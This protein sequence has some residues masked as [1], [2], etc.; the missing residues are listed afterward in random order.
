MTELLNPFVPPVE[1]TPGASREADALSI[2]NIGNLRQQQQDE[3]YRTA[4]GPFP[5]NSTESLTKQ[6]EF[7]GT[8]VATI[9]EE[10]LR[11]NG[12][13]DD[14]PQRA[15][16]LSLINRFSI[17]GP[18]HISADPAETAP[19]EFNTELDSEGNRLPSGRELFQREWDGLFGEPQPD[20]T[21]QPTV[22]HEAILTAATEKLGG[23]KTA[24]NLAF[25]DRMKT[26]FWKRRKAQRV[27]DARRTELDAVTREVEAAQI[28]KWQ[29]EGK[30]D[31]EVA[32]ALAERANGRV[33][34]R[35]KDRQE[36]MV[37]GTFLGKRYE[38]YAN[39]SRGKK[40]VAK[41]AIGLA[42]ASAVAAT[43]ATLGVGGAV[44]ATVGVA[45]SR[46]YRTYMLQQTELFASQNGPAP[47]PIEFKNSD[48]SLRTHDEIIGEA[49][50]KDNEQLD[51]RIDDG[52]KV[53]RKAV[54]M[55]MG[56]VALGGAVHAV[57]HVA[58]LGIWNDGHSVNAKPQ[59]IAS[60]NSPETTT[61]NSGSVDTGTTPDKV[62]EKIPTMGGSGSESA[63]TGS[64][65]EIGD[66]AHVIKMGEGWYQTF[67]EM[68]IANPHDQAALLNDDVLMG[69]L[70][71]IKLAYPD[72]NIGGWG[73]RM[74]P[75]G[76]MPQPAIDLIRQH[77]AQQGYA[78]VG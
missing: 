70:A 39:L 26:R 74:T 11:Q 44:F 61:P 20:D 2:D 4:I 22:D 78:L 13:G 12:I 45:T 50:Q 29:A 67:S 73:I 59:P 25:V 43:A 31:E 77:A 72:E 62:H 33:A 69:K 49:E 58:N 10:F 76:R 35:P 19:W 41:V 24:A 52:D 57:E 51:A 14:H 18:H 5:A 27:L 21:E 6:G 53:K 54:Y 68:G 8:G 15:Q 1:R 71:N 28:A 63:P 48:G 75:D 65:A 47:D 64:T 42:F 16:F 3:L 55:A 7:Y 40:L 32:E 36:A 17:H 9:N 37:A 46:G 38:Q 34:D 23:A 30:T 66:A 56:A 60:P